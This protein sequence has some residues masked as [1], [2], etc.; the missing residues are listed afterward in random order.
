MKVKNIKRRKK[1]V[2]SKAHLSK[3]SK[4]R[5]K[6]LYKLPKR[7]TDVIFKDLAIREEAYIPFRIFQSIGT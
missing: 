5:K 7:I 1:S 3:K 6:T 2:K 4:M